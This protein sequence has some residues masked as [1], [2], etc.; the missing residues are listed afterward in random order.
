[1]LTSKLLRTWLLGSCL[2]GSATGFAQETKMKI[3][4]RYSPPWW[5]TLVCMPDDPVKTLIGKEG[6]IFGD[7]DYK[8]PRDFSF[9][10]GLDG[11]SPLEWQSQRLLLARAPILRTVKTSGNITA[12]EEAFLQIPEPE[13]LNSIVRYDS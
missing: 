6:Q 3:D 8:G 9:S 13:G 7:Y 5:Q 11:R 2:L 4:H 12:T 1:M 10:L